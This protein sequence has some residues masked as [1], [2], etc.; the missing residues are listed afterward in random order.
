[1]G[2][3]E[4]V[5]PRWP[6][7]PLPDCVPRF[8]GTRGAHQLLEPKGPFGLLTPTSGSRA[9]RETVLQAGT[10]LSCITRRPCSCP[11]VGGP[12]DTPDPCPSLS[13]QTLHVQLRST[14]R[15]RRRNGLPAVTRSV[16]SPARQQL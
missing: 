3:V 9:L 7:G 14:S 8:R 6:R 1:M 4:C 16:S 15:A 11:T 10:L 13:L 12:P 5:S 2:F